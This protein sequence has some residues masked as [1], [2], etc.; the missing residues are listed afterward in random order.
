MVLANH[1]LSLGGLTK[2]KG[3]QYHPAEEPWS[4]EKGAGRRWGLGRADQQKTDPRQRH[5]P[6]K[7]S[8]GELSPVTSWACML[9]GAV[10]CQETDKEII[11]SKCIFLP[12]ACRQAHTDKERPL[13]MLEG[14]C[15]SSL[16][17]HPSQPETNVMIALTSAVIALLLSRRKT[18]AYHNNVCSSMEKVEEWYSDSEGWL[19]QIF[20]VQKNWQRQVG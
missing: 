19:C 8:Q 3:Y 7:L 20:R 5:S 17:E 16:S 15:L 2:G 13:V 14:L 11:L 10:T 9:Y 1:F 12:L 4:A 6:E 18:Q